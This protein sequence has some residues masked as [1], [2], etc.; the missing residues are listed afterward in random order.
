MKIAGRQAF[1]RD[2]EL[3]YGPNGY[4]SEMSIANIKLGV[5][6][7]ISQANG[8]R[9][10]NPRDAGPYRRLGGPVEVP[11]FSGPRQQMTRKLRWKSFAPAQR[12]QIAATLPSRSDQHAP[13]CRCS[14]HD[15]RTASYQQ[16]AK[17]CRIDRILAGRQR[18]ATAHNEGQP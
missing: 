18:K 2:Q 13:S 5:R 3:P 6:D 16:R 4:R 12:F 10:V 14:L 8:G 1:S 15:R 7:R 9:R 17:A 11:K